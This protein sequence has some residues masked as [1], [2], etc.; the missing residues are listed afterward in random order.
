MQESRLESMTNDST[1]RWWMWKYSL[2]DRNWRNWNSRLQKCIASTSNHVYRRLRIERTKQQRQQFSTFYIERHVRSDGDEW[3]SRQESH[4][5]VKCFQ[6]KW[7]WKIV[8][9]RIPRKVEWWGVSASKETPIWTLPRS[10]HISFVFRNCIQWHWFPGGHGSCAT[11]V[12]GHL[13]FPGR[14]WPSHETP[15]GGDSNHIF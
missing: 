11:N 13:C 1:Q 14:Y 3:N 6:S 2:L 7:I 15:V 5:V 12:G 8:W 10:F 4:G 9:R